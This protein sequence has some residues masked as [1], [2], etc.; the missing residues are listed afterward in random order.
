MLVNLYKLKI[1]HF[2]DFIILSFFWISINTGS[3]YLILDYQKDFNL[4]NLINLFRSL[5]PYLVIIYF[6]VKRN[7]YFKNFFLNCDLVFL[8]FFIYGLSQ[9]FGLIYSSVNYYE[10]YWI[11]CLFAIIFFLK[12]KI[13]EKNSSF[14]KLIF[15]V[16]KF[17]LL[18]LFSFFIFFT[19]KENIMS[20]TLLYH[21]K[22][23]LFEFSGNPFPRSSGLS[24]MCLI[25]FIF[26]N[27]IYFSQ[28]LFKQYNFYI[29][30]INSFL[31]FVLLT[32]QSRTS[33]IF[34]ILIFLTINIFFSFKN[35]RNR[36]L[37][38]LFIIIIPF[39]LS[40]SYPYLKNYLIEKNLFQ[41]E[42]KIENTKDIYGYDGIKIFRDDLIGKSKNLNLTDRVAAISN[43]RINAWKYLLDIFFYGKLSIKMTEKLSSKKYIF[44]ENT[45]IGKKNYLTGLGPQADRHLMQNNSKADTSP[46]VLGP[47]GAHAS[48]VFI[49]SL[50][51]S[52]IVGLISIIVIN[53]L[54]IYKILIIFRNRQK[55]NLHSDYVLSSSVLI[56]LFLQYRGLFENSYGVFGVDLILL[57]SS[58]AVIE[59][60]YRK[61]S[62]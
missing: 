19:F 22:A 18:I 47:F 11:V 31:V 12:S 14:I 42:I 5:L 43:N 53:L 25:L 54:I 35:F 59:K 45:L 2:K 13:D 3:K 46:L 39:F 24:R 49:Y 48:N 57:I 44:V 6:L 34:F 50:V 27:S 33:I 55:I 23:F 17:Y 37:Y 30:M 1:N 52:G 38:F 36:I 29:L 32:L 41:N 56:I 51:C 28:K 40:L 58:Y 7:K 16:N 60:V 26:L 20:E 62:E 10:H 61:T 15:F 9:L 8:F 21:S 4:N